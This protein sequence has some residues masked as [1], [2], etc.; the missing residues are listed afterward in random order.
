MSE[1]QDQT[2]P[3]FAVPHW[4]SSPNP[5]SQGAPSV[6][7]ATAS[8]PMAVT[9][10]EKIRDWYSLRRG[11][12]DHHS[13]SASSRHQ[14]SLAQNS[15]VDHFVDDDDHVDGVA[16]ESRLDPDTLPGVSSDFIG[17]DFGSHMNAQKTGFSVSSPLPLKSPL[18]LVLSQG[19][20][21]CILASTSARTRCIASHRRWSRARGK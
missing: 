3:T 14:Q 16:H 1:R 15:V 2:S 21:A 7:A 13:N 5:E 18:L 19:L 6:A 10:E 17:F 4:L 8:S 11:L 20:R 9:N 12:L